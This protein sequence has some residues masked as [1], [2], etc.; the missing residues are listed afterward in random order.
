MFSDLM[1]N[2]AGWRDAHRGAIFESPLRFRL[3]TY[4]LT[5]LAS[6]WK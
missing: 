2:K 6:R 4:W 3:P 1:R 5:K